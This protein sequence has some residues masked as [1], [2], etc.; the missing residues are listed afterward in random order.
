[1]HVLCWPDPFLS[2]AVP[3]LSDRAVAALTHDPV[4]LKRLDEMI[5]TVRATGAVG[6]AAT[7]VGWGQRVFV[8]DPGTTS[9]PWEHLNP[10]IELHDHGVIALEGC[11]SF[12]TVTDMLRGSEYVRLASQDRHGVRHVH[13]LHGV[14]ARCAEHEVDHLNGRTMLDRMGQLQRRMF[15]ARYEK[16]R[17]KAART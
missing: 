2:Q 11:L 9:M 4:W 7:Q 17:K 8:M 3:E 12:P 5:A 13:D 10:R 15:L 6:L 14:Q 1:M 16:A